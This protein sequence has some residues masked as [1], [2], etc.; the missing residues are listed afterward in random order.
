MQLAVTNNK[1]PDISLT[2]KTLVLPDIFP[3]HEIQKKQNNPQV[4]S[5]LTAT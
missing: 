4:T 5:E 3:D 1:F 2:V